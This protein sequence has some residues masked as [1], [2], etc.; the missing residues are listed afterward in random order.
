MDM[1]SRSEG[2]LQIITVNANRI[3]AAVAIQFKDT[4][5]AET[6]DTTPR[7]ILDLRQVECLFALSH[8]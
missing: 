4:M 8:A 2:P 3:D 6:E 7:V 1:S 5:R